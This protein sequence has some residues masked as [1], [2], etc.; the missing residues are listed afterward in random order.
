MRREGASLPAGTHRG[1]ALYTTHLEAQDYGPTEGQVRALIV[2][3][4]GERDGTRDDRG[5]GLGPRAGT[6]RCLSV[7]G[8][9]RQR[10][11]HLPARYDGTYPLLER[12]GAPHQRLY[13]AR[14]HRETLL[15]LLSGRRRPARQ[16]RLR[17]Q[18]G[19]G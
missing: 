4:A 17:A 19:R 3:W 8:R 9:E 10:L 6:C 2:S 7:A 16:A 13:A 15:D 5:R 12:G 14:D 11:R 18:G 1:V